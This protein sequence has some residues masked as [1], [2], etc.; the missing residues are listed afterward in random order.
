[1]DDFF[2]PIDFGAMAAILANTHNIDDLKLTKFQA[3]LKNFHRLG[4]PHQFKSSKGKASK[5][6]PIDVV[7]MALAVELTQ[8]GLPPERIVWVLVSNRYPRL[9]AIKMAASWLLQHSTTGHGNEPEGAF[10]GLDEKSPPSM[11][12][13]FDPSGLDSLSANDPMNA[14]DL[15]AAVDSFFYGGIGVVREMIA[16]WTYGHVSRI[17][18][19]NVTSMLDMTTYTP[20]PFGSEEAADYRRKYFQWLID[21]CE[22]HL[23]YFDSSKEAEEAYASRYL[24]MNEVAS[25]AELAE[26]MSIPLER[27]EQYFAVRDTNPF[28]SSKRP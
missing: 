24:F 7:D 14:P 10:P 20:F 19:I 11:F 27:A 16:E 2:N 18:L 21:W 6:N 8:L 25:A 17:S 12:L 23:E 1:M 5:Y 4:W 13:F 3:R 15:D 28:A 9:M 22:E 26:H